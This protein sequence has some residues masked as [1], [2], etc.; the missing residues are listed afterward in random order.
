MK[1]N[2]SIL[3]MSDVYC[4]LSHFETICFLDELLIMQYELEDLLDELTND[5]NNSSLIVEIEGEIAYLKENIRVVEN[6]LL[7]HESKITK[8]FSI[9]GEINY[10][11]FN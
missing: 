5:M 11:F 2:K 9:S 10:I 3:D 4:K 7:C 8:R 1:I 6:A